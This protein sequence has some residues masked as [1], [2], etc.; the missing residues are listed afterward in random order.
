[1]KKLYINCF[2]FI[3]IVLLSAILLDGL[4]MVGSF[5][6]FFSRLTNSREFVGGGPDEIRP[7]IEKAG[8]P[9]GTTKVILGD[10]VCRQLFNDLQKYND[11]VSIIGSNAAITMAGQYILAKE[12]L[13]NH[14]DATD[15]FL[16]V[17]PQALGRTYDT[18]HG[19]P[20]AVM[21]FVETDTLRYLEDST[22][23]IISETYGDFFL[24]ST[25]VRSL[26]L[27]AVNRKLYLNH[28]ARSGPGYNMT[29]YYELAD[30]YIP[31]IN[32][33]CESA[34]VNFY[35]YP[36]PVCESQLS[37]IERIREGFDESALTVINS[38]YMD[39]IWYYPAEQSADDVHFSVDYADREHLNEVI[40][41]SFG[42]KEIY[43]I[44]RL[45]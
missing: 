11:D 7:Y 8:T 10:S 33:M 28:L 2:K 13:D 41:E 27:S 19:Y 20:Y 44:I 43:D 15:V 30:I 16:I 4:S 34:G 40:K 1:M 29:D 36:C 5:R 45:E 42:D 21:P 23:G 18:H 26:D 24:N 35:L 38:D 17:L 32:E 12:Y 3:L 37:E 25:V 9:D 14:P 22:I 31:K 39:M 6:R